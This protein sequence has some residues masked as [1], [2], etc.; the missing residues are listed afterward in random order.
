MGEKRLRQEAPETT[1]FGIDEQ[2][3]KSIQTLEAPQDERLQAQSD[4]TP[5][6]VFGLNIIKRFGEIF[7]S[8]VIDSWIKDHLL[9]RISM[10][11]MGRKE[12]IV[13]TTGLRE[14]TEKRGKGK[15]TDL[16]AGLR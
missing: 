9:F 5:S 8:N 11:R 4:I 2:I 16:F 13:M 3:A 1:V 10:F 14:A 12:I 15:I 7:N 6:E